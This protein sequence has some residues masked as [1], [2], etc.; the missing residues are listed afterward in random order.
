MLKRQAQESLL[1][2]AHRQPQPEFTKT[3][4][5]TANKTVY[6][7][8]IY[9]KLPYMACIYTAIQRTQTALICS[10]CP[11]PNFTE[12]FVYSVHLSMPG[13]CVCVAVCTSCPGIV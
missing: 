13:W 5:F 12:H 4:Y 9:F 6:F 2:H 11:L 8:D 10:K 3:L 1:V 7:S